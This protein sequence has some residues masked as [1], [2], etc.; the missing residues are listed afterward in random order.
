MY[1][2]AF[3]HD[4]ARGIILDDAAKQFD[5]DLIE[6]FLKTEVAVHRDPRPLFRTP[7]RGVRHDSLSPEATLL[8]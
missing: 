5:P 6:A 8:V 2:N 4:V 3:A 1:K 7:R